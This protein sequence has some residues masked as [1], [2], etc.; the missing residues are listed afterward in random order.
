[1]TMAT[2]IIVQ[3]YSSLKHQLIDDLLLKTEPY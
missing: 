1:M 3:V 2:V